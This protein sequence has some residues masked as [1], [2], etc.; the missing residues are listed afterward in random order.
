MIIIIVLKR[1]ILIKGKVHGVGYRLFLYNIAESLELDRF[2]ADNIII[3]DKEVVEI[4]VEDKDDKVREFI[5]IINSKKPENAMVE[6]IDIYDYNMHIMKRDSYYRYLTSMQLFKIASYGAKMLEK[7]DRTLGELELIIDR[8]DS[9]LEELE[10]IRDRQDKTIDML[11][12]KL[13]DIKEDTVVIHDIKKDTR[14]IR[15]SITS[16]PTI[17]DE[18]YRIKEALKRHGIEV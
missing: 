7:Q 14:A 9:I 6:S 18:L 10:N 4:L 12:I 5:D 3:D 16:L 13:D 8:Q 11:R 17:L 1:R 15:E 2:F